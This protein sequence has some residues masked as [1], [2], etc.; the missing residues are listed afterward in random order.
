M[1]AHAGA[2]LPTRG[3][4]PVNNLL[5]PSSLI[6]LLITCNVPRATLV[7]SEQKQAQPGPP[8]DGA[9]GPRCFEARAWSAEQRRGAP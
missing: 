1:I 8:Y 9:L 4:T 7:P 3:A 2:T 6:I 5:Y